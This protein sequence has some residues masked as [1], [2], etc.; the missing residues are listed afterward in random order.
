MDENAWAVVGSPPSAAKV[1]NS[2][3]PYTTEALARSATWVTNTDRVV[4]VTARSATAVVSTTQPTILQRVEIRST[5]A[6][7]GAAFPR[8]ERRPRPSP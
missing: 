5:R 2:P 8:A 3:I 1:R 4:T 7:A 6:A